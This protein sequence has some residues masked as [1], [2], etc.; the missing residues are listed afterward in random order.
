[1]IGEREAFFGD[2]AIESFDFVGVVEEFD[3]GLDFLSRRFGWNQIDVVVTNENR[4]KP[5]VRDGERIELERL[6]RD[7][8][9]AYEYMRSYSQSCFR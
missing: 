8:V 5:R 4:Q 2:L 7:E 6:L 1:M 9:E 3:V